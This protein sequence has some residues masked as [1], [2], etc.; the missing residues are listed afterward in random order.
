[1]C[2]GLSFKNGGN[3]YFGRTLDV[4]FN[5]PV[6]VTIVPRNYDF[7]FRH[8]SSP[9]K[10]YAMI[11]MGF[12]QNDYPLLFEAVN[13]KGLGMAG[14]AL[15]NSC[16]YFPIQ[17][18]KTNV[19][20]FE[21]IQYILASCKNVEE[22]KE[23]LKE[24]N[25]TN[26]QFTD[27]QPNSPLHWLIS[28]ENDSIVLESTK[29][30]VNVYDDPYQVLT[31]EPPFPFHEMNLNYYCNVCN[32][33]ENFDHSRFADHVPNFNHIGAGLGTTQLPGGFDP[34]SR[35]V[36]AAYLNMNSVCHNTEQSNVSQFFHILQGVSQPLGANQ[37][38]PNTYEY[39]QYTCCVNTK[40]LRFYYSTYDNPSLN[41]VDLKHENLDAD[42]IKTYPV[43]TSFQV[44]VQN[45]S[46]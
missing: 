43:I 41:A 20:S 6:S 19:A 37:D 16:Q 40:T 23:A 35:F 27:K 34:I 36:R 9:N 21:I 3:H 33:I 39:T 45:V 32:H 14:L 44:N 2:T 22:A 28:D 15:W 24:I 12:V 13:E 25:I 18:G 46:R 5:C 10:H 38:Q 31:N 26:E 8:V 30:G 42:Q 29:D 11:G 4:E 17:E 7:K 1:M